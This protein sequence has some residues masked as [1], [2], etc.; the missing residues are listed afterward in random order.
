MGDV[1]NVDQ[2]DDDRPAAPP[3]Y[4]VL[5]VPDDVVAEDPPRR[6]RWWLVVA[7]VVLAGCLGSS[8]L[9]FLL[10]DGQAVDQAAEPA[11]PSPAVTVDPTPETVVEV[12]YLVTSTG[13]DDVA[14]VEY[15]DEDRD[16]IRKGEVSL[17]W[18]YTYRV[19]GD[20]PPLV[21]IAQRK[22][23]GTGP[24]TCTISLDGKVLT[25]EV[26]RGRYAS[27]QCSA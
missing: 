26:Q 5:P 15:T 21:V 10:R 9:G 6:P 8:I 20:K 3:V 11:I 27:P 23:G 4:P 18:R 19:V 1:T 17:P 14:R 22:R 24:V 7:A 12:I 25:T 2:G 13:E 16:I